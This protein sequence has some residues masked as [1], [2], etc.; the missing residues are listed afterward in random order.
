VILALL[1][2]CYSHES[3]GAITTA[4]GLV[5]VTKL[6]VVACPP[7]KPGG[8]LPDS[9][10]QNYRANLFGIMSEGKV[11]WIGK[12][13]VTGDPDLIHNWETNTWMY[14]VRS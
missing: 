4:P 7:E 10:E 8:C 11:Q 2:L 9:A 13:P 1:G 3:D 14:K 6:D 12:P 5:S